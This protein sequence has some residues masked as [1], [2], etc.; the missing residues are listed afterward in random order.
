MGTAVA[1]GDV[2]GLVALVLVTVSFL[3]KLRVEERFMVERFPQDYPGYKAR[4]PA[5]IPGLPF[6]PGN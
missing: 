3:F 2:R 6:R 5:L 1:R 4:T